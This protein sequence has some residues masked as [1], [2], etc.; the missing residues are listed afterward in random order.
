MAVKNRNTEEAKAASVWQMMAV[1]WN[2]ETFRPAAAAQPDWHPHY[3]TSETIMFQMV[4]DYLPP[5][6]EKAEFCWC[7][8]YL[9]FVSAKF[10]KRKSC[11][12][13]IF[14]T[15]LENMMYT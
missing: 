14:L 3:T 6:A 2:D 1:K 15:D 11:N 9:K 4:S 7:K 8:F 10:C 12:D 5:H 13:S